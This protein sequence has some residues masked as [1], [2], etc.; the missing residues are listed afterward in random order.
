MAEAGTFGPARCGAELQNPD[1][2]DVKSS[3][4]LNQ[5]AQ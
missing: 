2:T 4:V 1:W 5:E 3:K